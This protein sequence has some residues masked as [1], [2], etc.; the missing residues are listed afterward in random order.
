M[1]EEK[2]RR[3]IPIYFDALFKKIFADVNDL[4]P[5]KYLIEKILDVKISEIEIMSPEIIENSYRQKRTYLDLLVRINDGSKIS[6]EVNTNPKS[7]V[8]DRNLFFLFGVMGSSLDKGL[9]YTELHKH[10]QINLS[11]NIKQEELIMHYRLM[12][13]ETEDLLTDKLEIINIDIEKYADTWY[14]ENNPDE[15]SKLMGLIGLKDMSKLKYFK[16]EK[17]IIKKIIDKADKFRNDKEV[18]EIYDY[19]KMRD[20]REEMA[21]KT[22]FKEGLQEGI[23]T[24]VTNMLKEN[25]NIDLISKM[26]GLTTKE[27]ENLKTN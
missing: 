18:L 6:I 25:I 11:T 16:G 19:E 17:G 10:I 26:T 14:N 23:N 27:I 5:L 21:S 3:D 4:E 7:Y 9:N 12:D 15:L 2:I 13:K 8:I 22:A 24:V 1:I 20:E